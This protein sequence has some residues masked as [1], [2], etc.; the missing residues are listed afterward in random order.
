M[1]KNKKQV[2]SPAFYFF[3]I[4]KQTGN[5]RLSDDTTLR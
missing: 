2:I 3:Y 4:Y 5:Y 1:Q